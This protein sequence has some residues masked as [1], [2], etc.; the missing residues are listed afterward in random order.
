F[1]AVVIAPWLMLKFAPKTEA[2]GAH[3][4][5]GHEQEG[6]FG[7][8]YRR[9][10]A[11]I[12]RSRKSARRFLLIIG[13]ATILAMALFVTKTVRV[14]LLPFDNKSEL[15]VV[16]DLPEGSSLEATERVLIEAAR[17]AG[18]VEEVVSVDA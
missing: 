10:A 18:G 14:K 5:G 4:H 12:I 16:I 8:L 2:A 9:V 6:F 17:I 1:V 7:K 3:G 11:P 13:V 15:Q